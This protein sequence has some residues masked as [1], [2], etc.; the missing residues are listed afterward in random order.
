MNRFHRLIELTQYFIPPAFLDVAR[1]VNT[2]VR[3]CSRVDKAIVAK[4]VVFKDCRKGK[5]CFI[6]GNGP[7]LASQDLTCLKDEITFV[8]NA[9]FKHPV[10]H[11]WQP[12]YYFIA[13]PLFFDGSEPSNQFFS[14]LR[15]RITKTTIFV[16]LRSHETIQELGFYPLDH[17]WFVNFTGVLANGDYDWPDLARSIPGVQNVAQFAIMAAMYMGCSPIYLLGL[18]HDWLGH[19]GIHKAFYQGPSLPN[20]PAAF[21]GDLSKFSYKDIAQDIV[22]LWMG[23]EVLRQ[24]AITKGVQILNATS[25]GFLD[26]FERVRFDD[27]L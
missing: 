4:N 23:Y 13:D 7:S 11:H 21:N 18:D 3:Q 12:T 5:R 25:G 24:V 16:P 10:V 2:F 8:M 6:I 1:F 26:V 19:T 22:T 20:H 9:F 17:T 15:A 27:I 14:D